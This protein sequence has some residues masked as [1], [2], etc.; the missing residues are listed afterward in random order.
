MY[1][2]TFNTCIYQIS[3]VFNLSITPAPITVYAFIIFLV[4]IKD[5]IILYISFYTMSCFQNIF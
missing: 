3:R 5:T 1:G 4:G 2:E